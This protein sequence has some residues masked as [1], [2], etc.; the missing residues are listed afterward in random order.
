MF[1]DTA[2]ILQLQ[3]PEE[4]HGPEDVA[5]LMRKKG[6]STWAAVTAFS[7][8]AAGAPSVNATPAI[9]VGG[10]E[11]QDEISGADSIPL[12]D[13]DEV[14]S[15][16]RESSRRITNRT[17]VSF[18]ER[19]RH[20][21][22]SLSK[23]ASESVLDS[24]APPHHPADTAIDNE[25]IKRNF[26][27]KLARDFQT[28][29]APSHRIEHHMTQVAQSMSVQA[30]FI[31][32]PGLIMISFGGEDHRQ[33]THF[34]KAPGGIHMAK[35]AQV[36]AL[37]QTLTEKLISID[38]AIDLLEGWVAKGY[39][40]WVILLTY[41][42]SSFCISLLLFQIS[43]LESVIAGFLGLLIAIIELS[44]RNMVSGTSCGIRVSIIRNV[45]IS[46]NEFRLCHKDPY[47]APPKLDP[48]SPLWSLLFFVPMSMSINLLFQANKHQ[49]PIM[50][51]SSGLGYGLAA[52]PTAI[53]AIAGFTIGLTGNIYA[54]I[55]NDVA[56][57]PILSGILI[58]VPGSLSVKST[59]GFFGGT[60]VLPAGNSSSPNT[61]VV[62]G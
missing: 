29:G 49:W 30:D 18:I 6:I 57:A 4:I 39:P 41:P 31:L 34:I 24:E 56:I 61:S 43:W 12:K 52:T 13:A 53:T 10:S 40:D 37:C 54:R 1:S 42:V 22:L 62:D 48:T 26:L 21:Q 15:V 59:L 3:N 60:A 7:S 17:S 47:P 11:D 2:E 23:S 14:D 16:R 33:H 46:T 27:I 8:G 36:N 19:K 45:P 32:F 44:T 28:Y 38:D 5:K 9:T 58:Q 35:L 25:N 20:I 55:T 51:L 50:V